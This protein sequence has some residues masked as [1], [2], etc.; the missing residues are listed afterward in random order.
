MYKNTKNV[1]GDPNLEEEA[2]LQDSSYFYRPQDNIS[3]LDWHYSEDFWKEQMS[4][5]SSSEDEEFR[6]HEDM[7]KTIKLFSKLF[8]D[9]I[10]DLQKNI[11]DLHIIADGVDSFHKKAT[12]ANITGG[13]VSAAGGIVTIAGLILAPFTLGASLMVSGVGLGVAVAGGVTSASATISDTVSNSLERQ[14]VEE[15]IKSY[16]KDMKAFVECLETVNSCLKNVEEL[17]ESKLKESLANEALLKTSNKIQ[18]GARAGKALTNAAE[19]ARVATLAKA[20]G[21]LT[22]AIRVAGVATGVLSGLFLGLDVYFIAKDS[23]DLHN[24]AKTEFAT[25]IR[26]VADEL[27]S[28][29][30]ELNKICTDLQS[31]IQ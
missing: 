25:K 2:L 27:Q 6:L 11:D 23:I 29:L 21:G 22:R 16:Q 30:Q 17:N 15:I 28:G 4:G 9:R 24:G 8:N 13:T 26:E 19:I 7:H 20:S 10:Q 1:N 5:E 18:L 12:I 3:L 14:K 31:L